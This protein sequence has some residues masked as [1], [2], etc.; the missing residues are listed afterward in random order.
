[1]AIFNLPSFIITDLFVR[2]FF[3]QYSGLFG[4]RAGNISRDFARSPLP[5]KPES[6]ASE[7]VLAFRQG[8]PDTNRRSQ[9][10]IV[11]CE[12]FNRNRAGVAD[13]FQ[14]TVPGLP[15]YLPCSGDSPV[16]VRHLHVDEIRTGTP[17]RLL[18]TGFL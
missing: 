13:G 18:N 4:V 7:P 8:F 3:I 9:F 11:R 12:A 5:E 6:F 14:P 17:D 2:L 16:I 10:L 1:M 15:V